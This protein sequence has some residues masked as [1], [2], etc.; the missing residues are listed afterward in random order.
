MSVIHAPEDRPLEVRMLLAPAALALLL[1]GFSLRL[2]YL[3]VPLAEELQ[4]RADMSGQ[5]NVAKLA[6][7]GKIVDRTGAMLGGVRTAVAVTAK[8]KIALKNPDTI[9]KVAEMLAITPKALT[10]AIN[11]VAYAGEIDVP[12][13]LGADLVTASKIA[14]MSD[15]LPGFGVETQ[16]MR[17]YAHPYETGHIIGFVRTPRKVDIDRLEAKGMKPAEF[18]G[19]SGI[20]R[21]YERLLM[22]RPGTENV[23]VD[24]RRKEVNRLGT[25]EPIPGS[26]TVLSL[27]VKFQAM[28]LELLKGRRGSVVALD[29]RNGEVLCLASSPSYDSSL[30][31]KGI[32][33]D[34]YAELLNDPAK[35]LFFRATGATYPP[36]STFKI[37]TTI[38]AWMT[39]TFSMTD[40]ATCKGF[41]MV[42][43]RKVKCLGNHGSIAY[44]LA[45]TKSCNAY[46]G[47]LAT[48]V[49]RQGLLRACEALGLGSPTGLD[50]PAESSGILPTEKWWLKH[51]DRK[52]SLGDTVNFGIGQ[53]ELS[54]TPL[55][56]ASVV[57]LVANRGVSYKPHLLKSTIGPEEGAKPQLFKPEILGQVEASAERWNDLVQAMF[58]VIDHGTAKSAQISGLKWGGKTGSAENR[59]DKETHS[60]F[61]GMAPLDSPKIVIC[62]MVEN[63]GHGSEVAAPISAK[64]VK[65][66][67]QDRGKKPKIEV[68][69]TVN[70]REISSSQAIDEM[71]FDSP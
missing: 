59:K 17:Y 8:P 36:G 50:L 24:A 26:T 37:V 66:W 32:S 40:Q 55:Q 67:L 34:D 43:N 47:H 63:A 60:W 9:A 69:S 42:G 5:I 70:A 18:V 23:A 56:M 52:W 49:G 12:V 25:D 31:L 15:E 57:A 11:E 21:Q 6:P 38:G 16:A 64:L 29:P 46:F 7:R 28:A 27:D 48:L 41:V 39:D 65:Y 58:H 45:F 20:E 19:M 33:K 1:I 44:D 61:V 35:P 54:T 4:E 30:F 62:V 68:Q 13:F 22:G 53:G 14:E 10:R 2:W 51:R 71:L 3:Q